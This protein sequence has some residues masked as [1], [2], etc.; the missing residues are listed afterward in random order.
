VAK[1]IITCSLN[2]FSHLEDHKHNTVSNCQIH[3]YGLLLDN[4]PTCQ[5]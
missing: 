3:H 5:L 2:T 1:I 4:S